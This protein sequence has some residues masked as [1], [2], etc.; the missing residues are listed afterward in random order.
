MALHSMAS[1]W[2][3]YPS[4]ATA[5]P[6][7]LTRSLCRSVSLPMCVCVSLPSV[8]S[9]SCSGLFIYMNGSMCALRCSH[10][11]FQYAPTTF[12][13]A[14]LLDPKL[15]NSVRWNRP[16]SDAVITTCIFNWKYRSF[17][18]LA[19]LRLGGGNKWRRR[20][21]RWCWWWC[22]RRKMHIVKCEKYVRLNRAVD[23]LILIFSFPMKSDSPVHEKHRL[24]FSIIIAKPFPKMH[25]PNHMC[26]CVCA[27]E[28]HVNL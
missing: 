21:R 20:Q 6:L 13:Y 19:L 25:R 15:T 24:Q 23:N 11:H 5:S 12:L 4:G 1:S 27:N 26:L 10:T 7:D 17:V 9:R 28:H 18:L 3:V 14:F 22:R 8:L 2:Y 16:N